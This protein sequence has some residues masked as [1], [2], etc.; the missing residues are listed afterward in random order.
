MPR[1]QSPVS[2]A[3][4]VYRCLSA[5]LSEFKARLSGFLEAQSYHALSKFAQ[6]PDHPNNVTVFGFDGEFSVVVVDFNILGKKEEMAKNALEL[7]GE[8]EILSG[9]QFR[10]ASFH[11]IVSRCFLTHMQ[12]EL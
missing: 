7:K 9:L 3:Y 5:L 12:R 10:L 8:I 2:S 4:P 1:C 6:G 11:Y